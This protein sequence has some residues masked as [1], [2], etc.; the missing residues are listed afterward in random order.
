MQLLMKIYSNTR[1]S[2]SFKTLR[3]FEW[4]NYKPWVGDYG[5]T[6]KIYN[7]LYDNI[8]MFYFSNK[9]YMHRYRLHHTPLRV[10]TWFHMLSC[11]S[12]H[13]ISLDPAR[14]QGLSS[15][16]D[17]QYW[18]AVT[19]YP[20]TVYSCSRITVEFSSDSSGTCEGFSIAYTTGIVFAF[21][22]IELII[23][24]D[25]PSTATERCVSND[26][27]RHSL[28]DSPASSLT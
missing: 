16:V 28:D 5:V 27:F 13:Q 11:V 8:F 21:E 10:G 19:P 25:I 4:S 15:A 18:G 22:L 24:C 17:Y 2:I 3:N 20:L 23:H 14:C 6:C 12:L 9:L 26:S 1:L 7:V